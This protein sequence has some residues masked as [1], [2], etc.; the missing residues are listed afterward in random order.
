MDGANSLQKV[1][2]ITIPL[3]R[4]TFVYLLIT[5]FIT[6][7]QVFDQLYVMSGPLHS[8][9]GFI[10]L[11]YT[12]AFSYYQMGRASAMAFLLFAIIVTLTLIQFKIVTKTQV[13]H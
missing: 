2:Y 7:F 10:E 1:W 9:R 11:L 8:T 13:E 12:R 6:G 4:P 5:G 3:L